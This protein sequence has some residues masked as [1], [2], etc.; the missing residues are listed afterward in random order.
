MTGGTGEPRLPPRLAGAL[1]AAG[2]PASRCGPERLAR[3]SGAERELYRWILRHF[4]TAGR[5]GSRAVAARARQLG[6]GDPEA[7]LASLE[8]EDLVH[9][10]P[11]GEIAVAYPFAG[12]PT[13]HE[14]RLPDGHGVHAMCAVDALGVA[15]MLDL[16]VTIASRDP[17]TG[18]AIEVRADPAGQGAWTPPS[19]VVVV[20]TLEGGGD[21]CG[22]CCPVLNFFASEQGAWR[23]LAERPEVR[24]LVLSI[25]EALALGRAIFGDLL[26]E[27][28]PG[29]GR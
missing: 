15:P 17:R 9:R 26:R 23:W 4:A 12:S 28:A 1:E 7:A 22:A 27:P 25:P 18:A 21:A 20:G 13:A 3:L 11:E 8:R 24:G 6:I 14:V 19:A 29:P 10:G 2:I 16:P 5:P